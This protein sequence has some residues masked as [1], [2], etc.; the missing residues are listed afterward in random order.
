MAFGEMREALADENHPRHDEA[1]Q[2][3]KRMSEKIGPAMEEL[4]RS[5]AI[6]P[7][8]SE[9]AGNFNS[10]SLPAL[11][12]STTLSDSVKA[13]QP[14]ISLTDIPPEYEALQFTSPVVPSF[15]Y[16]ELNEGLDEAAREKEAR[17]Q[18]Q[19]QVATAS[20]EVLQAMAS[21][22][23]QLDQQMGNVEQRLVENNT[24][25]ETS[26]RKTIRIA[27]WTLFATVLGIVVATV[28]AVAL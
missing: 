12:A 10:L 11:D 2:Q 9:F 25:A 26:S 13:M 16:D 18:R 1:I 21:S 19:D 7:G 20:L 17:Q 24:S 27:S 6:P 14:I 22:I 28:L 15:D 4:K 8:I 23:Q 3:G 5:I